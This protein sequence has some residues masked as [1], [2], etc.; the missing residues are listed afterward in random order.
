V[1]EDAEAV[2]GRERMDE[3]VEF[4]MDD[5]A[6]IMVAVPD[7]GTGP[8]RVSRG[9]GP[10][11]AART[12]EASLDSARAAAE[13]ALRVFRDGLLR[14]DSVQIEFGVKLTAETGAVLVKGSAEGHLVV[15]LAWSPQRPGGQDGSPSSGAAD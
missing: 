6:S 11:Q 2:R 4:R 9:D 8:R 1:R 5:G 15:K 13:A 14:P 12:F 7:E 10:S 3:L